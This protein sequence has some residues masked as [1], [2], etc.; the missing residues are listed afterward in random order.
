[1]IDSQKI[2]VALDNL[3]VGEVSR[4]AKRLTGRVWGFKVNDLLYEDIGILSALK[5]YG[6]VFADVKLHDIPNTV[7]NSV[8]RL[9][10]LGVDIITV[11]ASGGI[12]MM[13]AAKDSAGSAKII[14]VTVLTSESADENTPRNV[15]RLTRDALQ[16]GVDGVVCSGR[17][18]NIIRAIPGMDLKITVVPG[19]RPGWAELKDQSRTVTPRE[20]V[21]AGADFLVVGRPITES[22]DCGEALSKICGE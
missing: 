20:A 11:H 12:S 3:P 19:I 7:Q 8:R 4:I 6:R 13:Q 21:D 14:A 18:L 15:E 2:I 5:E 10:K 1:M 16:G 22:D 9:Q 17:E